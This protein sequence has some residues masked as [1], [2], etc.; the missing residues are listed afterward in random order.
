MCKGMAVGRSIKICAAKSLTK[1]NQG[2]M[3]EDYTWPRVRLCEASGL[4]K[5]F[6]FYPMNRNLIQDI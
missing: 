3:I 2:I 5:L 6:G 1:D 4:G